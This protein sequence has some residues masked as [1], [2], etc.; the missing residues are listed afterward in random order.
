MTVTSASSCFVRIWV[1]GISLIVLGPP[2]FAQSV[3][4]IQNAANDHE[5]GHQTDL[6]AGFGAGEFTLEI[7]LRPDDSYPVGSVGGGN[8][9][10]NWSSADPQPY[11][12]GSW[13]YTGNFLLDGHNNASFASG[14][15]SLQFVGGG[16]VRW[17]FGDG[18]FLT[19]GHWA[20][21][22]WPSN[23]TPSLLDGNWHHVACVRRWSGAS[24]A[25]LELWIDGALV[26][27]ETSNRRTNMESTY[28][29]NWTG[30]PG[31][32]EGWFWGAEKQAAIGV[33]S[34]YEDYKGLVDELRFWS[35]AKSVSE[36]QND[37]D[38]AV[39][40]SETGLVGWYSFGEGAGAS[41]CNDQNAS[42][43]IT[44]INTQSSI[45][46]AED[47]PLGNAPPPADADFD[48]LND[49]VET[50][51]GTFVDEND[52]GTDPNDS[53][54]DDDGYIDGV[55]VFL[56]TDPND[57]F[58]FPTGL[59]IHTAAAAALVFTIAAIFL[60]MRHLRRF[61]S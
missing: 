33:L 17:D 19:G 2:A 44:L 45:W 56:G 35:R 57:P 38:D 30:F 23:S 42:N 21:Q 26:A 25:D 52:T 51:T 11:S 20:V 13:W 59:R 60:R 53:D 9:L 32:Q 40:G 55:E 18:E 50:D 10:T 12:S 16:R 4:F 5:Y 29:N 3:N 36:L 27:T 43:C 6:P 24:S 49:N 34:A 15:F 39:T 37:W 41:A 31:G 54:T 48:L 58:D 46:D 61:G 28:W 47:A 8:Q 7:W 22:A 14:T 1:V